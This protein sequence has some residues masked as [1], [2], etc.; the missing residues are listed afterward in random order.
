MKDEI[1]KNKGAGVPRRILAAF[2]NLFD[3]VGL[4]F[5][6]WSKQI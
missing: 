6:H 1:I 4:R 5:H 3:N 2:I